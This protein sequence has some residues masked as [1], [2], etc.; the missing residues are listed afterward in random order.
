MPAAVRRVL[1]NGSQE[2]VAAS[3]AE[4]HI[5]REQRERKGDAA[6]GAWFSAEFDILRL[7]AAGR[8]DISDGLCLLMA[9][10]GLL[11]MVAAAVV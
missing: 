9:V 4:A 10:F 2:A 1:E 6:E 7:G 11:M 8:W 5:T 3:F